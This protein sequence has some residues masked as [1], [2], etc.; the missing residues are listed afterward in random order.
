MRS[1]RRH[2]FAQFSN[3]ISEFRRCFVANLTTMYAEHGLRQVLFN[4]PSGDWKAGERGLTAIPGG[5]DF[6]GAGMVQRWK[7]PR[8]KR[9]TR[10]LLFLRS[11]PYFTTPKVNVVVECSVSPGL[12]S[13]DGKLGWFG[14]SGKCCVSR[15]SP[16]CFSYLTPWRPVNDP[17]RKLPV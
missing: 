10:R 11:C 3:P 2:H 17:S 12:S 13:V 14:E 6:G 1:S 8:A 7:T 5:G 9:A 15:Q 4:S 16:E